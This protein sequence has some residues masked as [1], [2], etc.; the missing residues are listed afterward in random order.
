MLLYRL[1]QEELA[2]ELN[3]TRQTISKWERGESKP[4]LWHLLEIAKILEASLDDLFE[5]ELQRK[6]EKMPLPPALKV[7]AELL[8]GHLSNIKEEIYG[9]GG[10]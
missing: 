2:N 10:K 5:E 6:P 7:G 8:R 9:K 1:S 4:E 3:V